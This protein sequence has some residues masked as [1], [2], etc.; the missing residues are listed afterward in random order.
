[1]AGMA[2]LALSPLRPPMQSSRRRSP[3]SWRAL[4]ARRNAGCTSARTR[5]LPRPRP[6]PLVI[7]GIVGHL[8]QHFV[9]DR[10]LHSVSTTVIL[11]VTGL[12]KPSPA[13]GSLTDLFFL[14]LCWYASR[15]WSRGSTARSWRYQPGLSFSRPGTWP[16]ALKRQYAFSN[17]LPYGLGVPQFRSARASQLLAGLTSITSVENHGTR[18]HL[19]RAESRM[20]RND[21]PAD[22][23]AEQPDLNLRDAG[24]TCIRGEGRRRLRRLNH[25][26][27]HLPDRLG[28]LASTQPDA[29]G[30]ATTG[31]QAE[32]RMTSL[33]A[34][35]HFR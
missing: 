17:S 35:V 23:T 15:Y 24:F 33:A 6:Y 7:Q 31:R 19:T 18:A 13:S 8:M 9:K 25:A 21:V 29:T 34:L 22:V 2:V 12:V 14:E 32:P 1:M 10:A 3:C 28:D 20:M 5:W 4:E 27:S 30:N 11:P 16:L 26:G